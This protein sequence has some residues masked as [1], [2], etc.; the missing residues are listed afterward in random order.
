MCLFPT[1]IGRSERNFY[2]YFFVV[3]FSRVFKSHIT[4]QPSLMIHL[5]TDIFKGNL[6]IIIESVRVFSECMMSM[7]TKRI[8]LI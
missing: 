6:G 7:I 4:T 5:S 8:G 1:C 3:G 2:F